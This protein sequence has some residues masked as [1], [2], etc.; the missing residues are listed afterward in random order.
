M[1]S[2]SRKVIGMGI[3]Q[4]MGYNYDM[5]HSEAIKA[6][7]AVTTLLWADR[8]CQKLHADAPN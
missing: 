8:L 5:K 3:M 1:L 2:H 7:R 6:R 4:G